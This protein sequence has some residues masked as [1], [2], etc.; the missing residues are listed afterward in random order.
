MTTIYL[1]I[2]TTLHDRRGEP[3]EAIDL[4]GLPI[5]RDR[6][7]TIWQGAFMRTVQE[8]WYAAGQRAEAR[9]DAVNTTLMP[10]WRAEMRATLSRYLNDIRVPVDVETIC[11]LDFELPIQFSPTDWR[12]NAIMQRALTWCIQDLRALRPLAKVGMY[13]CP[14]RTNG[15][16]Y[17]PGRASPAK[18]AND[19]LAW[20]WRLLDVTCIDLYPHPVV[21]LTPKPGEWSKGEWIRFVTY[22]VAE[23]RR[24]CPGKPCVGF[25]S[26]FMVDNNSEIDGAWIDTL[27]AECQFVVPMQLGIDHLAIWGIC[28]NLDEAAECSAVLRDIVAP[29]L[30]AGGAA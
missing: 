14:N 21:S 2:H 13:P 16:E 24:V 17:Q 6:L 19:R 15:Y 1:D 4:A 7:F 8:A 23:A 3:A 18:A 5:R 26:L 28:T 29:V 22:Q 10:G 11:V 20:L 9:Y 12:C 25:V 27:T 30:K